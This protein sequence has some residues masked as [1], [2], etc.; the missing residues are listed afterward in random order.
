MRDEQRAVSG[1]QAPYY[2]A[3]R[4]TFCTCAYYNSRAH[5]SRHLFANR[6]YSLKVGK[7]DT[8][9]FCVRGSRSGVGIAVLVV[10]F[11]GR[12]RILMKGWGHHDEAY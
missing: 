2:S 6:I 10:G 9:T 3:A 5:L 4:S 1:R 7:I 8:S 11:I 12:P